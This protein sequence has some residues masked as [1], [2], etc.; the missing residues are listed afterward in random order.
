MLRE[1]YVKTLLQPTV[2]KLKSVLC[3]FESYIH[4]KGHSNLKFV[5]LRAQ[6]TNFDFLIFRLKG[7]QFQQKKL[8]H[9]CF[10]VKFVKLLRTPILK[11]I[12]ERLFLQLINY[13]QTLGKA[14]SNVMER[15][16]QNRQRPQITTNDHKRPQTTNKRLQTTNKRTLTTSKRPQTTTPAHQTKNLTFCFFFPY[17]VI[18]RNT[19]I[20]KN[21]I[22]SV[23]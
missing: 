18:T 7:L 5:V 12:R 3:C 13:T 21:I 6:V 11:N 17:P 14:S 9:R 1:L 15:N 20:L 4:Q 16:Y 8:Q 2:K 19:L 10:P 23:K 22:F